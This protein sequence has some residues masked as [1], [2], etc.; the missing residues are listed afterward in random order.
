MFCK[1]KRAAVSNQSR[2]FRP[3]P[4]EQDRR[5]CRPVPRRASAVEN[6]LTRHSDEPK[7]EYRGHP[8]ANPKALTRQR[9]SRS[10]YIKTA[11]AAGTARRPRGGPWRS[12]NL[13]VR[14]LDAV[15][16]RSSRVARRTRVKIT[17]DRQT[18]IYGINCSE[19]FGSSSPLS[20]L[21]RRPYSL[22]ASHESHGFRIRCVACSRSRPLARRTSNVCA[23]LVT[24][25][26]RLYS[27]VLL[28]VLHCYGNAQFTTRTVFA[29]IDF[30]NPIWKESGRFFPLGLQQFNLLGRVTRKPPGITL[31]PS[32]KY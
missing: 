6:R 20:L 10:A 12:Y 22:H 21:S 32:R 29:G 13:G 16:S 19:L 25:S 9:D 15:S 2:E 17:R 4:G 14:R 26:H 5:R 7:S 23:L 11:S 3:N 1:S 28:C 27:G 8:R 18:P 31:L 30:P 24:V